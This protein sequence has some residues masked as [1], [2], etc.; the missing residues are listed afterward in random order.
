M[1]TPAHPRPRAGLSLVE[2]L[3]ALS[4]VAVLAALLLPAV[5]AAREA[6]RQATCQNNLR[7]VGLALADYSAAHGR[8][9]AQRRDVWT[10]DVATATHGPAIA[11]RLQD[12]VRRGAAATEPGFRTDVPLFRCPS[13]EAAWADGYPVAN[14]AFNP[15]LL[16]LRPAQIPD[17]TSRTV[18]VIE[19]P[20]RVALTWAAGPLAFPDSV[21]SRHERGIGIGLADGSTHWLAKE[22][23]T[24]VLLALLTPAG[25]EPQD[26]P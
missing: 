13:D 23:P 25:N 14:V 19:I 16:G 4:I 11:A 6:G 2:L 24:P 18:Q 9:P 15:A 20:S 8:L 7:Q 10:I 3:V 21:G 5:A 26:V 12:A 17:G 1:D 22:V